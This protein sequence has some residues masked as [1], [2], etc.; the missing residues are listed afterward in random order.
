MFRCV[1]NDEVKKLN[2]S[3]SNKSCRFKAY[4]KSKASNSFNIKKKITKESSREWVVVTFKKEDSR[5]GS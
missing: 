3:R 1:A 2:L 4:Q 5:A